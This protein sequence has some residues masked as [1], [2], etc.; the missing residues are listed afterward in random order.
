VLDALPQ[1]PISTGLDHEPTE[2]DVRRALSKLHDTAPGESGLGA[3]LWKALAETTETLELVHQIVIAFWR[4]EEMP[5]EWET[6]LLAILAKKGD[7]SQAGNYRGIMMLEVCYKIVARILLERLAPIKERLDHEA[8]CGF[9]GGRG[10]NDGIFTVKQLINKRREHGLET[11]VLFLDLVKAFDRVPRELLWAVMLKQGVPPK[12]VSLLKAM[13][14]TV[15]VKF[16]IDGVARILASIIGV[17]QG[18][19]LGPDGFTFFMAAVM[20]TWRSEHSYDLCVFRSRPDSVLTGRRS[21][22]GSEADEFSVIDSEYAD[23][24]GLPFTSRQDVEEQTPKVMTHFERWGMEIHAGVLETEN[25]PRKES[26]SEIL[27]CA[28]PR[29]TYSD[30]TTY[31]GADLSDVLLPEG[32]FMCIVDIFKYLGS[33]ISRNGSDT[34]DVDSRIASAG[35]AFGALSTCVFK[36]THVTHE[37]KRRVYEGLVLA[38]LLYASECWLVTEHMRSK[39]RAFHAQCLR[40]MCGV[41]RLRMWSERISTWEL[42]QDLG[43][44][45]MDCYLDRRRLRWLGHMCRMPF[46]RTP[47][48]MLT[49]WVAAPR[50]SG[51]QLMTYGRGI[52]RALETFN[53]PRASWAQLAD[54]RVAWRDAIHGGLLVSERP[55]RAAAARADRMIDVATADAR[56]GVDEDAAIDAYFARAAAVAAPPPLPAPVPTA[57]PAPPRRNQRRAGQPMQ[58]W[59]ANLPSLSI[60][61][62][63]SQ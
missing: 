45:S 26:K 39:L 25:K 62:A 15:H 31:D 42:Q 46:D 48:R 10:G 11:W 34:F 2:D 7:L 51:G 38:I 17:K 27:F 8:Q 19:L 47:R 35:K 59:G 1:S 40:T 29:S 56:R 5:T 23:D 13:H 6:G 61:A 60:L 53:I 4:S 18:D 41:K 20:A 49:S 32:L 44:V 36:S 33:Y 21:T 37:A 28:A 63:A 43:L 22:T 30:P 54:D 16:E 58:P 24:T 9:R 14:A 50:P 52:Y 3:P 57:A 55:K 12:L